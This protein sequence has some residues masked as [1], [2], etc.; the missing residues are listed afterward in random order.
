RPT[1][2]VVA[3]ARRSIGSLTS[4]ARRRLPSHLVTPRWHDVGVD[5]G[6]AV[7]FSLAA[8]Q[9]ADEARLRNLVVPGFCS[10]PRL[11]G[12]ARSLRRLEHG[13][14]IVAVRRRGRPA[15]AVVADMIDGVVVAN[16]LTGER[17][18]VLRAA[19]KA[20]LAER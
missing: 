8:R 9:L 11:A 10:P 18:T 12:V 7:G 4:G 16:Q 14:P 6:S 15:D 2:A 1:R 20:A 17:A 3:R 19:L 5:T 13:P